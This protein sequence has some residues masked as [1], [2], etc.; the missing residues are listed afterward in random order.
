MSN[1]NNPLSPI[2]YTNK[3]FQ[4][5]YP[6][7]LEAAKL[8]AKNWDPTISNESDPGVVLLKLNAIIGDKNNYNIDKNVLEN[9]PETYTQELSA[10]SQYRQLGYKM[11][12]YRAATTP[13]SFRWV[14]EELSLGQFV[15]IPRKT[16]LADNNSEYVFTL[17]E[18][19][20]IRKSEYNSSM[21]AVGKVMQGVMNRLSIAGSSTITLSQLDSHNRLYINDTNVAENGIFVRIG[22]SGKLWDQVYNV[23]TQ[24]PN[25]HCYEF[26]VDQ[27]K[28]CPYLQFPEDIYSTIGEG[29][30]VDYITTDGSAGN[31]AANAIDR[32][33][34]ESEVTISS[35]DKSME[36]KRVPLNTSNI[37]LSNLYATTD[38]LADVN[39]INIGKDPE[40]I[41]EARISYKKLAGTFDT[42]VTLRD[43][44]N[45]IYS[46]KP[47]VISNVIVTD[48][49]TDIQSSYKIISKYPSVFNTITYMTGENKFVFK[50]G[51]K[52]D[53]Y[54]KEA[55]GSF[56]KTSTPEDGA[57]IYYL[58]EDEAKDMTPFDLKLYLLKAGDILVTTDKW[59]SLDHY[60]DTFTINN[61]INTRRVIEASLYENKSI[62]HDFVDIKPDLPF[63]LQAVYPIKVK[64]IPSFKLDEIQQEEVRTN[65]KS[66]LMKL[67]NSRRC[68]FGVEPSYDIIYNAIEKCDERIKTVIM[69]D[70][71][72]TLF[73]V[74]MD[75]T[76]EFKYIPV[77]D[78]STCE[79]AIVVG[80]APDGI[81]IE[82]VLEDKLRSIDKTKYSPEDYIFIDSAEG[83]M[84]LAEKDDN[85]DDV[86]YK[87]VLYSDRLKSLRKQII[88]KNILAGVTPLY[89]VNDS[90][91]TTTID[92]RQTSS[93]TIHDVSTELE[94]HPFGIGSEYDPDTRDA[95]YTLKKNESIKCLAP[96]FIMDKSFSS[97]TKFEMTLKNPIMSTEKYVLADPADVDEIV[98]KFGYSMFYERNAN[99]TYSKKTSWAYLPLEPVIRYKPD[100]YYRKSQSGSGDEHSILNPNSTQIQ[101]VGG[102]SLAAL[103][104]QA[105]ID[106]KFEFEFECNLYYLREDTEGD[107]TYK[108]LKNY[109]SNSEAN[110]TWGPNYYEKNCYK[111]RQVVEEPVYI[112]IN[113][114]C[115]GMNIKSDDDLKNHAAGRLYTKPDDSDVYTQSTNY[116]EAMESF[117]DLTDIDTNYY[118]EISKELSST[119]KSVSF[120]NNF[121]ASYIKLGRY[122]SD[123]YRVI[124]SDDGKTVGYEM[125]MLDGK[126]NIVNEHKISEDDTYIRVKYPDVWNTT[127]YAIRYFDNESTGNGVISG[128]LNFSDIQ[129]VPNATD[130]MYKLV[131]GEYT[132]SQRDDSDWTTAYTEYYVQEQFKGVHPSS[133][134]YM[135]WIGHSLNLYIPD[136]TYRIPAD[137]EYQLREGDMIKF[138][139]RDVDESDAPY[140]YECYKG[141]SDECSNPI[142]KTNFNLVAKPISDEMI[143]INDSQLSGKIPYDISDDSPFYQIYYNMAGGENDLGASRSVEIRRLNQVRMVIDNKCQNRYY[144]IVTNDKSKRNGKE[145]CKIKLKK[146]SDSNGKCRYK[147]TLKAD[148]YFFYVNENR[149]LYGVLGEGTLIDYTIGGYTA[150]ELVLESETANTFDIS[151]KGISAFKEY[152]TEI[153]KLDDIKLI[154]QQ[155]YSFTEGDALQFSLKPDYD[156][157]YEIATKYDSEET[158]YTYESA[159]ENVELISISTVSSTIPT[160]VPNHYYKKND[161]GTYILLEGIEDAPEWNKVTKYDDG[162]IDYGC[163]QYFTKTGGSFV[164]V[165]D[166]SVN[167]GNVSNGSFYIRKDPTYPILKTSSPLMLDNIDVYYSA[168][169]ADGS[170]SDTTGKTW[171]QLPAINVKDDEYKWSVTP[172]LNLSCSSIVAQKIPCKDD[173]NQSKCSIKTDKFEYPD[174]DNELLDNNM[175]LYIMTDIPI[176]KTGGTN[177]DVSWMDLMGQTRPITLFSYQMNSTFEPDENGESKFEKILESDEIDYN[178]N[179]GEASVLVINGI[180]LD[181]NCEH[182]LPIE[183]MTDELCIT[184]IQDK[185]H[186]TSKVIKCICCDTSTMKGTGKHFLRLPNGIKKLEIKYENDESSSSAIKFHKIFKY[187]ERE[188]FGG[189]PATEAKYGITTSELEEEIRALDIPSE[190][191]YCHVPSVSDEILDPLD[192]VSIFRG[193][194]IFNKFSIPRAEVRDIKPFSSSVD[195]VNNR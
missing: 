178:I 153:T 64:I 137:T 155:V 135:N 138:F 162:S 43:Y 36:N 129:Y 147:Y 187:N 98:K 107:Y 17:L 81:T 109:P 99:G 152:C 166:N 1:M 83:K 118:I 42:L 108:L 5:I 69:D 75:T 14:G 120:S 159:F 161:D 125:I 172:H 123:V 40:T 90:M 193:S 141:T 96:S 146:V 132:E 181:R 15:T 144:Y 45:A 20:T 60:D 160:F 70:F 183:L 21:I 139:W 169:G 71:V 34:N 56:A 170:S 4:T 176:E 86:T 122:G 8:L 85:S 168:A 110:N 31:V 191:D 149:T 58:D 61:D 91:F 62:Q 7:L 171:T 55:D 192:P 158:Y 44:M 77:S 25:S 111:L 165:T 102:K 50:P 29:L 26:D 151:F 117:D 87:L 12:W 53:I 95:A 33:A 92:M 114:Y 182:I 76:G 177:V 9:Y 175:D 136:I 37:K 38:V 130:E 10:R 184:G 88:A 89:E 157:S 22:E 113:N 131:N 134:E 100:S 27:R 67:L 49:T 30:V 48:R 52:G 11:P 115:A 179:K 74:Y 104:Q 19:V 195:F 24:P 186:K 148:E 101:E 112:S 68:E 145:Y 47:E 174:S 143:K 185:T 3:D 156:Y 23:D 116:T 190:F 39:D 51:V 106:T 128:D 154:E 54:V 41:E 32:Y 173:K 46:M 2:S 127:N 59:E 105:A 142:I 163:T 73:A 180:S 124:K 150:E 188:L 93:D 126:G 194:H 79:R 133:K 164:K 28:N 103:I 94:I 189:E 121:E 84:Y 82:N 72:Y 80:T 167:E 119:N 66:S 63:M 6:E 140:N 65:I 57:D 97:Y 13:V 16:T 18:D 78:Y 35:T